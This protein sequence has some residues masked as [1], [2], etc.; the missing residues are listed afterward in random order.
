MFQLGEIHKRKFVNFLKILLFISIIIIV[1]TYLFRDN[2]KDGMNFDEVFRINNVIPWINKE[3]KPYDQSIFNIHLFNIKIPLLYKVYGS[4]FSLI[5]YIPLKFFN[6]YKFGLRFLEFLYFCLSLIISFLVVAKSR[7]KELYS[8]ISDNWEWFVFLYFLILSVF[9][10]F[11]PEARFNFATNKYLISLF[12]GLILLYKFITEK[13]NIFLFLSIFIFFLEANRSI[14]FLWVIFSIFT[15][16]LLLYP[17]EVISNFKDWKKVLGLIL[18][19][20]LGFFNFFIYNVFKGFPI[21][22]IL[23]L[24]LFFSNIYNQQPIDYKPAKALHEEILIKIRLINSFL[25]NYWNIF[26]LILFIIILGYLITLAFLILKKNFSKYRFYFF[27]FLSFWILLFSILISPNTTRIGHYVYLAPFYV[28]SIFNLIYVLC[29]LF[30]IKFTK[31]ILLFSLFLLFLLSFNT[32]NYKVNKF[33][34]NYGKV[35][36]SPAIY[37][38]FS[39]LKE[40][41]NTGEN[42]IFFQ[43]GMSAQL[44]FLNKGNFKINEFIFPLYKRE[45]LERINKLKYYFI[46]LG[47]KDIENLYFPLYTYLEIDLKNTILEFLSNNGGIVEEVTNFYE[48]DGSPVITLYRLLNFDELFFHLTGEKREKYLSYIDFSKSSFDHQLKTGWYGL[49][50]GFRWTGKEAEA[51]LKNPDINSTNFRLILRGWAKVS[52]YFIK[53]IKVSV[54][55]DGE[56]INESKITKNGG[57]TIE[58]KV[59]KKLQENVNLKIEVNKTFVP[60]NGDTRNL[61]V[62]IQ[63][64]ELVK[65]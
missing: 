10:L 8:K 57:F 56:K 15:S 1:I 51:M 25:G 32:S 38:L 63:S 3:A 37:D 48:L 6:D 34:K 14:Y 21:L 29:E 23:F 16:F 9:P 55:L 11:F 49:E 46:S 27:P 35:H 33:M 52:E 36:H 41:K 44:Y 62:I 18:S 7:V 20:I 53:K 65:N 30:E 39:Y 60:K 5:F 42:F 43:W 4:Y 2:Y 61:G 22:K 19:F 45:K 54:Y 24:K 47:K 40:T 58:C 28:W 26:I 50:E 17:K 64:I 12:C 13:K 31:I 59:N